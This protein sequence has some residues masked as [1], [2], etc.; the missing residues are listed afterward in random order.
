MK[1]LLEHFEDINQRSERDDSRELNIFVQE[2]ERH[3]QALKN[4]L[5]SEIT[6][7]CG[8]VQFFPEYENPPGFR[9]WKELRKEGMTSQPI[10][11]MVYGAIINWHPEEKCWWA[12]HLVER[13][14]HQNN[15][16]GYV[17]RLNRYEE[18]DR[19]FVP[20]DSHKLTPENVWGV[21]HEDIAKGACRRA[22]DGHG[23][24]AT[25]RFAYLVGQARD[26]VRQ[27]TEEEAKNLARIPLVEY[28]FEISPPTEQEILET[29]KKVHGVPIE[30]DGDISWVS[31]AE[32]SYPLKKGVLCVYRDA[33]ESGLFEDLEFGILRGIGL[34][35]PVLTGNYQGF[36]IPLCYW[37]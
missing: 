22:H 3:E 2:I 5:P 34:K 9:M 12:G 24:V 32:L 1:T 13:L 8:D 16:F 27:P 25:S 10:P 19:I 29:L 36:R 28:V 7:P 21:T 31:P 35:D 18:S 14:P 20:P 30:R 33:K 15:I 37:I 6:I 11:G 17:F 23:Y 26:L 4:R